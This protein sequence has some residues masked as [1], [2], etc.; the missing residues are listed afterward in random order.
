MDLDGIDL[1]D[2]E[3]DPDMDTE[4]RQPPRPG[5]DDLGRPLLPAETKA[6]IAEAFT[7]LDPGRRGALLLIMDEQD[8]LRGHFAANLGGHW[9]VAAGGGFPWHGR[10]PRGWVCVEMAW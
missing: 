2:E 8:V 9:K 3:D 6:K 4:L 5:L 1:D 7:I 10:K